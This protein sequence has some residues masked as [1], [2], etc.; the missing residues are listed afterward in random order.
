MNGPDHYRSAELLLAEADNIAENGGDMGQMLAA[1][2]V[3]ATLALAAATAMAA[4]LQGYEPVDDGMAADEYAAWY[5][6][7]GVTAPKAGGS[8]GR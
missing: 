8:D 2:Q 7:A 1:A 3:H 4:P 6:A 5:A